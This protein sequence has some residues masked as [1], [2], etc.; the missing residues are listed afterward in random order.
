MTDLKDVQALELKMLDHTIDI[1]NSLGLKWCAFGGTLIGAV[2]HGGFIPWDDDID[3]IMPRDDFNHLLEVGNKLFKDPYFFQTPNT[4]SICNTIIKIR[5]NGTAAIG[6]WFRDVKFHR[7]VFI[8]IF[9]LD[10]I[11][12]D[13]KRINSLMGMV[14]YIF[15]TERYDKSS[16]VRKP[17]DFTRNSNSNL[18][19]FFNEFMTH[20]DG[21]N[22]NSQIVSCPAVWRYSNGRTL[23]KQEW[24]SKFKSIKFKG[25]HN[26]MIVPS[27]YDEILTAD[28]GD[29]RTPVN[30]GNVHGKIVFDLSR[31]YSYYDSITMEDFD[32]L[33]E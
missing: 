10:H 21:T 25:L 5:Y 32:K 29:W 17:S 30:G 13:D 20:I 27:N 22:S 3:I 31:D 11:P 23:Y 16:V 1:L 2:R 24:F 33:F 7:G 6:K 9:P 26:D 28:F 8:D 4:D 19:C 15:N 14:D 18:F 12:E